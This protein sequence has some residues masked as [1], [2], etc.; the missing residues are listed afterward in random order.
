M[1]RCD[2]RR[3]MLTGVVAAVVVASGSR[4]YA[5]APDVAVPIELETADGV[6]VYGSVHGEPGTARALLLVF[7]QGGGN[8]EAEYGALLPR[9]L[10]EGYA[11]ITIDQRSGGSMLGGR[12]RTA[13]ALGHETHYCEAYPD[14][15]AALEYGRRLSAG[16]LVA[17][18]S[19]YSGALALRLASEH[20]DLVG[21][22]GFSPAGGE[23]MGDCPAASFA[24]GVSIP[25]LVLRP[26]SELEIEYVRADW[27]AW[28]EL[29]FERHIADP[30]RHGSSMLNP[31]LVDGSVEP[32]W[33]AVLDFLQRIAT[34]R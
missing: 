28:G 19:S 24:S 25:A 32:T 20:P 12:N 2:G 27:N 14:L 18:G 11:A 5:Q 10:D 4:A 30:G 15:E 13:D 23:A 17:W 21:V 1:T 16:P 33:D 26:A 3:S 34:P 8:A 9:L 22:L 6:T 29:G 31:A 7:H